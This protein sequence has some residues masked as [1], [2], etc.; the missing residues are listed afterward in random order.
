MYIY[1]PLLQ[2]SRVIRDKRGDGT[3][4]RNLVNGSLI[5]LRAYNLADRSKVCGCAVI[6][7]L[8]YTS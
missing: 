5:F 6:M 7:N 3:Y 8:G 4:S 2:H 1:G